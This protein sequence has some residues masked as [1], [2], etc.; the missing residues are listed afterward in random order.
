MVT[1]W[2]NT[3]A[4]MTPD[5]DAKNIWWR[6]HSFFNKWCW[7]NWTLLPG[8]KKINV[9]WTKDFNIRPETLKL[10]EEKTGKSL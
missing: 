1:P 3:A 4:A 10:L 8:T 5:N 6:K 7:K 2:I 9:K